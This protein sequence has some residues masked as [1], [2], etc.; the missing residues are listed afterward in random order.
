[1]KNKINILI[2]FVFLILTSCDPVFDYSKVVNN[3][4]D[5]DILIIDIDTV[6]A[7]GYGPYGFDT[8]RIDKHQTKII[9]TDGGIGDVSQYKDCNVYNDTLMVKIIGHDSLHLIMDI[10][11]PGNWIFNQIDDESGG[12]AECVFY[13]ENQFIGN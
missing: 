11:D 7:G 8:I 5:Y 12:T 9:V 3:R 10:N 4:S 1:M 2:I 13:I 6:H